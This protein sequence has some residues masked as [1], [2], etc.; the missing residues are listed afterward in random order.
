MDQQLEKKRMQCN[1]QPAPKWNKVR[2]VD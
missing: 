1:F 2:N